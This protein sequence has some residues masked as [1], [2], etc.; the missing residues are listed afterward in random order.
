MFF[1]NIYLSFPSALSLSVRENPRHR[2]NRRDGRKNMRHHRIMALCVFLGLTEN[3]RNRTS[4]SFLRSFI[5]MSLSNLLIETHVNVGSEMPLLQSSHISY[6]PVSNEIIS[7]DKKLVTARYLNWSKKII[8]RAGGQGKRGNCN[9][10]NIFERTSYVGMMKGRIMSQGQNRILVKSP[11][12][13][14]KILKLCQ[15]MFDILTGLNQH[16]VTK[17]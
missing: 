1:R 14:K 7:G 10:F 15:R 16:Y 11:R 12:R 17:I 8:Q 6:R 2:L 9:I 3:V 4:D 5:N 13:E